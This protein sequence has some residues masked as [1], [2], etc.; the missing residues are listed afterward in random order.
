MT[1]MKIAWFGSSLV[2]AYWNGAA[3]Y[4][5]GIIRAL[6]ARGHAVTFYE[7]DAFDRQEHRDIEDPP[8]ARVQ[9]YTATE[10]GAAR[11][12]ESARDAD[13]VIKSSGVG[14]LDTFL[15]AAVLDLRRPATMVAFWDVDAP[16]TLDRVG[17]DH[18]DPFRVYV[19]RYDLILT[20]GGG[21]LVVRAYTALGARAC[22]PIHNA[23]D[24]ETHHPVPPRPE[25][26][27][28]LGFLGNRLPD[29]EARVERFFLR[30]A[31]ALPEQRFL[32][33]GCGWE[34]RELPGNVAYLGHVYT[35]NHNA[36]NCSVRAVLNISRDSMARYGFSPATRV[37][38]AAGAG[39]CLITDHWEGIERFLEPGQEVLV[40]RDGDEVVAHLARLGGA[41]AAAMGR[42]ARQ[43]VLSEHTYAHRAVDL[44]LALGEPARRRSRRARTTSTRLSPT[45]GPAAEDGER[46]APRPLDIVILGLSITSSWGNGHATTYRALV[47]ALARR[48]HRVLFLE[49]DVPWYAAHRDLPRPPY[50]RTELYRDVGDL[51]RRFHHEVSCADLVMVGSYVPEGVDV[52]TWVLATASGRTAF[53]DIDTPV[54]LARLER[55]D[56]AYISPS[57]IP[58]YDLYLSF[59]G[60]PILERLEQQHGARRAMPLYCSVDPVVYRPERWHRPRSSAGQ[61]PRGAGQCWD[62][63]YMG[64]YSADRQAALERLLIEPARRWSG[65]RFLV[66]GPQYPESLAWP[67]NVERVAHVSPAQH[68]G[69]YNGLR[70][71]L[72]VTRRD[73]V[74]AG[75][76]PSVRL[77]EAAAC[78]TPVISDAWEGLESFFEVGREILVA[79]SAEEICHHLASMSEE[80][81]M[82]MAAR[83]RSRIL[84]EHTAARRAE[85]LE[86]Y[87]AGLSAVPG[88]LSWARSAPAREPTS[89]PAR[90]AGAMLRAGPQ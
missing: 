31:A 3:T 47:R 75:Y 30:A 45:I 37:F 74:E 16:A 86:R 80:E 5:R 29:R 43:R 22:V 20:Y 2:S 17:R 79:R 58:H 78:G 71:A 24:P 55:G 48:G 1:G 32:L 6:A 61:D 44:E 27:G 66:A 34:G 70:F 39:A 85:C 23:L 64:T 72:N 18:G 28:T 12:L 62:L 68:P 69:F 88:H 49:R 26:Q 11:A 7:P 9:V 51:R 50:A 40:A 76:A 54:T 25:L 59:T 52:G 38:E 90:A 19:P 4:Y 89:R 65:G 10:E 82:A 33:G 87:L 73:M 42:R 41:D 8:W 14:V 67:G 63:G 84:A 56:F 13:L 81:R 21:P 53:Y 57:L 83:A 35:R 36:F 60:G 77:F 15:E 46:R